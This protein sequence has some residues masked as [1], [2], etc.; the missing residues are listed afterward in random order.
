MITVL[1]NDQ[2][3]R[4]IKI[5]QQFIMNFSMVYIVDIVELPM[6]SSE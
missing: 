6:P 1:L 3:V 2:T 4:G 5:V